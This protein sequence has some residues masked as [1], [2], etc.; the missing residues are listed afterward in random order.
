MIL[1]GV[2][3]FDALLY[4]IGIN[5]DRHLKIR[6]KYSVKDKDRENTKIFLIYIIVLGLFLTLIYLYEI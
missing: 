6:K 1:I 3:L 5:E 2:M 4:L